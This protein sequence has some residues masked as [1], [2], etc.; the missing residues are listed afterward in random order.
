MSYLTFQSKYDKHPTTKVDNYDAIC[1]YENIIKEL[2]EKIT[3]E[4][5]VMAVDTYPGVDDAE[6]LSQLQ[7]LKPE[8]MIS[9]IDIFKDGVTIS[10][11]MKY[12][13]T[14]DRVFGRM[15]YGKLIDFIDEDKLQDA[16]EKIAKAEGL[17]L[18]YG[19]G[20]YLLEI[21][22]LAVYLDMARWEIQMRLRKGESNYK[23]NN[24]KEDVLKK[25]KRG[26][27]IEWRVADK[28]KLQYFH[29]IDY[30]IDTNKKDTP[31]M[32]SGEALQKGLDKI[33]SKP[34]RTVPY[35]DPGV[36]G[37]QWMKEVCNLDPSKDNY[38]WS[39]DGVPEENSILLDYNG[40]ILEFPAMDV[41]LNRPKELLGEQVYARFGAEFPIR[42][43][44]LDTMEGASLS[45]QVHPLVEYAKRQFGISYTQ[46]ESYYILDAKAGAKVYLG[47]KEGI[48]KD[49][50]IND[51]RRANKGEIIFD[52]DKYINT[53]DAKKHDHF[54]IPAGTCH[55]SGSGA[56]VLE[57]SATPYIFTFKLWDWGRVGLDGLPRPVHVEHGKEVIQWERTTKWVKENLVNATY[58]IDDH[59]GS[60]RVEH[61]GLHALE[62]IETR[63]YTMD[64]VSY[65]NTNHT[66]NMLN[67]IDG[68]E[69]IV[70]SIDNTFEP[71]IVHYAETF[72][73]PA[74]I[75]EYSI[76][77]YGLSEGEEI[78]V[79]KAYVR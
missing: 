15:Y 36:W 52:A 64:K 29:R 63:R 30:F 2:K 71:F 68:K 43:D 61:T 6:V 53:F 17:V 54:L 35:F 4:K 37:G 33:V 20:A 69:A 41:V 3:K 59:S 60:K 44:F 25:Y 26:Y 51:L 12:H 74:N 79:I 23:A 46:D 50:M 76:R 48:D 75:A 5:F 47:L 72:I 70:E 57:I 73:I 19:F 10:E 78:K 58:D 7:A 21:F 22:D 11:Q 67:L 13:L 28:H 32:I 18:V 38:A 42:F 31:K 77:P 39:F 65:H 24:G 16:K 1:G 56:M 62:F 8:L 27:F 40:T 55:C 49:E 45:L 9:M 66:V 34:F 14:D